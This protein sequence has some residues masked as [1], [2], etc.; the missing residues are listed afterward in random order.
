LE[1][2]ATSGGVSGYCT[3]PGMTHT[4]CPAV[5][6]DPAGGAPTCP[7]PSDHQHHGGISSGRSGIARAGITVGSLGHLEQ[8]VTWS[9]SSS[10]QC[11]HTFILRPWASGRGRLAATAA[12][13]R[14]AATR[15]TRSFG[16]SSVLLRKRTTHRHLSGILEAALPKASRARSQDDM[17][18]LEAGP[19]KPPDASGDDPVDAACA[20]ADGGW[21]TP[22]ISKAG[23]AELRDLM[24][25]MEDEPDFAGL[26]IDY[27]AEPVGEGTVEPGG[28]ITNVR[29][30]A[31]WNVTLPRSASGG[32]GRSASSSTSARTPSCAG[33]N[34][35]SDTGRPRSS[36]LR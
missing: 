28:I 16:S 8:T 21:T 9:S 35:N 26:W 30:R 32:A 5:P 10:A 2:L 13:R 25:T 19:P 17:T 3:Q 6:H 20:Q 23:D 15:G 7:D 34:G 36:V 24:R 27:V 31:I 14:R 29:S 12:R 1:D 22:D 33:S 4:D 11:R 18:V